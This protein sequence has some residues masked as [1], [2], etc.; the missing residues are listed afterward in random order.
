[1]HYLFVAKP[2][3]HKY[4]TEWVNAYDNLE[5]IEFE[6]KAGRRHLYEWVND[7]PLNGQPNAIRVNFLRYFVIKRE[8]FAKEKIVYQNS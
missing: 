5:R 2:T 8:Q 4:M 7:V 1:M 6:D 3:D